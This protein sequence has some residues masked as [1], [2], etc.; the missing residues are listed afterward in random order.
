MKKHLDKYLVG[1]YIVRENTGQGYMKQIQYTDKMKSILEAA[2]EW[3][4][5]NKKRGD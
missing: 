2:S 1:V 4:R 5:S 3:L